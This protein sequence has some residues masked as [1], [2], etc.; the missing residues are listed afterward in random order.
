[1]APAEREARIAEHKRTLEMMRAAHGNAPGHQQQ[2]QEVWDEDDGLSGLKFDAKVFFRMHDTT[3]DSFLD[4][5]ELE[6]LFFRE[7]KQLHSRYE[8]ERTMLNE[9]REQVERMRGRLKRTLTTDD[10]SRR[11]KKTEERTRRRRE[12]EKKR[13]RKILKENEAKKK[14]HESTMNQERTREG[15]LFRERKP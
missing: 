10:G 8:V 9:E 12:R 13:E 15:Y 5:K 6:A 1:M 4:F 14:V 11:Q 3:G 2:L 7:A